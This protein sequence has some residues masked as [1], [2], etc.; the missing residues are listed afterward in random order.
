M[1]K[2][3]E[4]CTSLVCTFCPDMSLGQKKKCVDTE[5]Y[6]HYKSNFYFKKVTFVWTILE[7][8]DCTQKVLDDISHFSLCGLLGQQHHS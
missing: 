8:K 5:V 6:K 1:Y 2:V 3:H 4:S 7:Y